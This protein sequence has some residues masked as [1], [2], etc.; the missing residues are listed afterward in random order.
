[1]IFKVKLLPASKEDID[2]IFSWYEKQ[3]KIAAKKF[4]IGLRSK[5]KYIQKHPLHCQVVYKGIRTILIDKF[6]H[7]IYFLVEEDTRLIIVFSVTHT[8]RDPE[9]WKK[10]LK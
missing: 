9:I 5:L 6:P 7:K 4:L 8:S 10:R 2:E 3:N 1:M